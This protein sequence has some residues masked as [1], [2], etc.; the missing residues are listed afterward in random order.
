MSFPGPLVVGYAHVASLTNTS[1]PKQFTAS[2]RPSRVLF[3]C[4]MQY[5]QEGDSSSSCLL[6]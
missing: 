2:A 1:E 3:L 4:A 5:I 6:E